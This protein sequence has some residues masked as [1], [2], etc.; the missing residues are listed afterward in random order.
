M[1]TC[2]SRKRRLARVLARTPLTPAAEFLEKRLPGVRV[3]NFHSVPARYANAFAR[4]VESLAERYRIADPGELNTLVAAGPGARAAVLITFDDGL[5]NHLA[6]AAPILERHEIRAI[7]CIPAGFPE[8]PSES[9]LPWYY[10]RM[11]PA[12]TELHQPDDV[13]PLTWPQVR[14]LV[15]RGHEICS[16]GFGHLRLQPTTSKEVLNRE[17]VESRR[18]L[19]ERLGTVV[20]GF[21]WPLRYEPAATEAEQLI[22][23]TYRYALTSAAGSIRAGQDPYRLP[24]INI[25]ASWPPEVVELQL[26]GAIDALHRVRKLRRALTR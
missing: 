5:A 6:V 16:H 21:C 4:Q 15:D 12:F 2:P 17:I 24:R 13:I 9:I 11:Y 23:H 14:E 22:R 19:E 10:D 1:H 3:L 7:F 25:E 26:S 8:L 18:E 20:D